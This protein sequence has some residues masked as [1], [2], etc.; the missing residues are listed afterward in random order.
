MYIQGLVDGIKLRPENPLY[1]ASEGWIG[2]F[3]SGLLCAL[4]G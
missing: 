3:C 2:K 4:Q 1:C